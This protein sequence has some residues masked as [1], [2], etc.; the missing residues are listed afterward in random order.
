MSREDDET[1]VDEGSILIP[2]RRLSAKHVEH[3]IE[4]QVNYPKG[5]ASRPLQETDISSGEDKLDCREP[6]NAAVPSA[7]SDAET[8][9]RTTPTPRWLFLDIIQ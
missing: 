9:T 7:M 8:E 3:S 6:V 1:I 5:P 4:P 2:E